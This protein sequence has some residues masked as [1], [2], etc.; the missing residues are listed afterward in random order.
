MHLSRF[1]CSW[2]G[3]VWKPPA[4][5]VLSV[6]GSRGAWRTHPHRLQLLA[7][8]GLFCALWRTGVCQPQLSL[9]N[10]PS[11]S[12]SL[13]HNSS[14]S[15]QQAGEGDIRIYWVLVNKENWDW[16]LPFLYWFVSKWTWGV[17]GSWCFPGLTKTCITILCRWLRYFHTTLL[18]WKP[19]S[20]L[21]CKFTF[22]AKMAYIWECVYVFNIW[23]IYA[24]QTTVKIQMGFQTEISFQ[25]VFYY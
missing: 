1:F 14:F 10:G 12:Q 7:F 13:W 4:L 3:F 17:I 8:K 24:W 22:P 11:T 19:R 6:W 5:L 16:L 23:Y 21:C 9:E 18:V 20:F 2:P 15:H 25:P